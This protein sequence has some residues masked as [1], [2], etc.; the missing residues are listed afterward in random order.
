MAVNHGRGIEIR[1]GVGVEG[2]LGTLFDDANAV[3]VGEAVNVPGMV[4]GRG[5]DNGNGLS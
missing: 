3:G 2:R 5:A 4:S 1:L